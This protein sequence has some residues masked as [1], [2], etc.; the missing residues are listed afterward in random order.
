MVW[1]LSGKQLSADEEVVVLAAEVMCKD[2]ELVELAPCE[3]AVVVRHAEEL[4]HEVV[5]V[6]HPPLPFVVEDAAAQVA[7]RCRP[8]NLFLLFCQLVHGRSA[9][10][11]GGEVRVCY[12][13]DGEQ[14]VVGDGI[15]LSVERL[16]FQHLPLAVSQ[17]EGVAEERLLRQDLHS[18]RAALLADS[19]AGEEGLEA[20]ARAPVAVSPL[21]VPVDAFCPH[22]GRLLSRVCVCCL[23]Q[24]DCVLAHLVLPLLLCLWPRDEGAEESV[25]RGEAAWERRR[26]KLFLAQWSDAAAEQGRR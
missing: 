5:V 10:G 12:V 14:E 6:S 26:N 24:N 7:V 20:V 8:H 25:A 9:G 22:D 16:V 13:K 11:E 17:G 21:L 2:A 4:A 15:R 1:I 23:S 18:V 19:A 3:V